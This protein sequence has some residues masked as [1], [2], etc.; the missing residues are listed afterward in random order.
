MTLVAVKA[1]TPSM[2]YLDA[3]QRSPVADVP[4]AMKVMGEYWWSSSDIW[5]GYMNDEIACI[6]GLCPPTFLSTN[7]HLW[8]LTTNLIDEHR[9]LFVR[10]SQ[11][12]IEEM[13]EI[14]P[15]ITGYCAVDNTR[16]QRWLKWLGAEFAYPCDGFVPFTIRKH[17][18]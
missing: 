17:N 10:W 12:Y 15:E 8:L 6:W 9:F 5:V 1:A 13:L 14:Y 16:A 7:A 18:G 3:V 4:D 2:S 11:R